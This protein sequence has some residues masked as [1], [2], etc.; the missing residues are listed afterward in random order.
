[1]A[2]SAASRLPKAVPQ[3]AS[4]ASMA[5]TPLSAKPAA[6]MFMSARTVTC[7][8]RTLMVAV[9]RSVKTAV[10]VTRTFLPRV[11]T[12]P[13][14]PRQRHGQPPR[15]QPRGPRHSQPRAQPSPPQGLRNL[16]PGQLNRP[17]VLRLSLRPV[18]RRSRLH[19]QRPAL[20]QAAATTAAL[21][22]APSPPRPSSI[23][24]PIPAHAPAA[25]H[26]PPAPPPARAAVVVKSRFKSFWI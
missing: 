25:I 22:R 24:T 19:V 12:H 26:A 3:S 17:R 9:G 10:G 16:R 7:T 23:V 5:R 4:T 6:V 2:L 8:K 13:G 18:Q 15:K 20:A 11:L 1:M 21:T 14:R